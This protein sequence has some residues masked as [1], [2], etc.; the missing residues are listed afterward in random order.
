[1]PSRFRFP[2]A[3][4]QLWLPLGLDPN[5]K[6]PGGFNYNAVARLKPGFT[7]A[8]AERDFTAVLPRILE[9]YPS[10]APGVS[11]Q[12]L[13]DQAKPIPRIIPLQEDVT[14]GI[15]KT[16][17]MVAA[18]A[19]LVLLVACANVTNLVLVRSDGRQRELA[20]REALGAGRA[21]VLLHFMAEASLL[22][23]VAAVVGLG[24]AWV[25]VRVLVAST[26]VQIPRLSEVH[27]DAATV[28]F[29]ILIAML[30]A[31]GRD[32]ELELHLRASEAAGVSRDEVR[33]LLLQTA[34]YCG[35]PAANNAF[36]LAEQVFAARDAGP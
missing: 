20:V 15:A 2:E 5:N 33:E 32:D 4:T 25:A 17:W 16:L 34:I 22:S 27:I 23:A 30:V 31:L 1:M 24:L 18:A 12:M 28:G 7:A 3:T 10:F 6:F 13:L 35:V 29:T 36:K 9:L 19:G 11:T 14:G 21:R 26:S 8:D